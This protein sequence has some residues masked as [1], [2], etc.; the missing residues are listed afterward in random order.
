[1]TVVHCDRTRASHAHR[2]ELADLVARIPGAALH[3]WYDGLPDG[4]PLTE[5]DR[6]GRID[7]SAIAFPPDVNAYICGPTPFM[8]E[9]VRQLGTA[10]VAR[11]R[12]WF[13]AFSPLAV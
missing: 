9:V 7:L 10:G 5:P 2:A 13:E 1:V 4:Y 6:H 11:D 12:I 3:T 8:A